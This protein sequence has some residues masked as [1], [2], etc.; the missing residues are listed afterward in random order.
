MRW[1]VYNGDN[2]SFT[3]NNDRGKNRIRH[4]V[5]HH[6]SDSICGV[7]VNDE[8]SKYIQPTN[9]LARASQPLGI[10]DT[11]RA[12]LVSNAQR[13]NAFAR[14]NARLGSV[15]EARALVQFALH[16]QSQSAL[17]PQKRTT[18]MTIPT[19]AKPIRPS[20]PCAPFS[21][22]ACTT[23]TSPNAPS[24]NCHTQRSHSSTR[25]SCA[26]CAAAARSV[27][28]VGWSARVRRA[29]GAWK[30][31]SVFAVVV[32]MA[33]L[34]ITERR[35][36]G[37]KLW[38]GGGGT[39]RLPGKRSTCVVGAKR[40][41]RLR[42]ALGDSAREVGS[43]WSKCTKIETETEAEESLCKTEWMCG[44][45]GMAFEVTTRE[46]GPVFKGWNFNMA[47]ESRHALDVGCA[48]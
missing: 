47:T 21:A 15:L 7:H 41:A 10:R 22:G 48:E 6:F 39:E 38:R 29:R 42:Y 37:G 31:N 8:D 19:I 2:E 11:M 20:S 46:I 30:G 1:Y 35:G 12:L 5:I 4:K 45:S 32:L 16:R 24:Q 23:P 3:R 25:G 9:L 44:V 18:D 40:R 17:H 28:Q 14:K 13:Q 36:E 43:G 27:H 26:T 34:V 33:V